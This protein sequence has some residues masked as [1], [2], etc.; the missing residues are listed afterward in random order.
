[1]HEILLQNALEDFTPVRGSWTKMPDLPYNL[2]EHV[3]AIDDEGI[4][5]FCAGY[6]RTTSNKRLISLDLARRTYKLYDNT[7]NTPPAVNL[8]AG[9]IIGRRFYFCGGYQ[10][11]Y[12]IDTMYELNLDTRLWRTLRKMPQ[13]RYAH[14]TVPSNRGTLLIIGGR[15][16]AS[17]NTNSI[18]EY[19]PG[20][21]TYT[22]L[23]FTL[24][25]ADWGMK[26]TMMG[27]ELVVSGGV[28]A[29]TRPS[30][31][32]A[33]DLTTGVRRSLANQLPLR[34]RHSID[35]IDGGL[36]T[37]GGSPGT[38]TAEGLFDG[39]SAWSPIVLNPDPEFGSPTN[40][41]THETGVWGHSVVITGGFTSQAIRDVWLLTL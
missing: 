25:L 18:I 13:A 4:A 29:G 10:D 23:P 35:Y 34:G 27:N 22:T 38:P 21:D 9:G 1:M 26:A 12:G 28:V 2:S 16:T 24:P 14:A 36:V 32:L 20:T 11:T 8:A 15:L 17:T 3:M 7:P 37:Y 5:W 40:R 30:T 41:Y 31:V 33:W 19:H 6:P 39:A